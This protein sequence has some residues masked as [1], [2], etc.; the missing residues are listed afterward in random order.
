MAGSRVTQQSIYSTDARLAK[1][2]VLGSV[3]TLQDDFDITV[4]IENHGDFPKDVKWLCWNDEENVS[5]SSS[6]M[7]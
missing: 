5:P 7:L 2:M 4:T 3:S 1:D 6:L